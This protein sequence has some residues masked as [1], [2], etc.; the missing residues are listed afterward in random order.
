MEVWAS[1]LA[2]THTHTWT[3]TSTCG[4]NQAISGV[5][6]FGP[7][8]FGRG[9][10]GGGLEQWSQWKNAYSSYLQFCLGEQVEAGL[11]QG[12]PHLEGSPQRTVQGIAW[13]DGTPHHPLVGKEQ[14]YPYWYMCRHHPSAKYD[15]EEEAKPNENGDENR[16]F[17]G[18]ERQKRAIDSLSDG[19]DG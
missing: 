16:L 14:C 4:P 11:W 5:P 1:F 3:M 6:I 17:L 15:G 7:L 13:A 2:H 9:G 8:F 12:W 18:T 10:G 19:H